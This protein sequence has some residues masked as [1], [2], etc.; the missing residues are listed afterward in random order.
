MFLQ[1]YKFVNASFSIVLTLVTLLFFP[2]KIT[3]FRYKHTQ[4]YCKI[5]NVALH[6]RNNVVFFLNGIRG[7]D[8]GLLLF[9]GGE[10]IAVQ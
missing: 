9:L 6:D 8:A 5:K 3:T 10:Q 1:Q 4:N 2:N 7:Q